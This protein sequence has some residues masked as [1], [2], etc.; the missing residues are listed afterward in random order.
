MQ[1]EENINT[2]VNPFM[3]NHKEKVLGLDDLIPIKLICLQE[4]QQRRFI[5]NLKF[6]KIFYNTYSGLIQ[7]LLTCFEF[8]TEYIGLM[9]ENELTKGKEGQLEV[10]QLYRK[11][12]IKYQVFYFERRK[13]NE[14]TKL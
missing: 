6:L 5:S 13:R 1:L 3:E 2:A 14:R 12:Q 9:N 10:Q 8:L 11:N 4:S 7:S